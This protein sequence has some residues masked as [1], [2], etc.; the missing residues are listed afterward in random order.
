MKYLA[1]HLPYNKYL[2]NPATNSVTIITVSVFISVIANSVVN[3]SENFIK[4]ESMISQL[5]IG[6]DI[7][8]SLILCV[9]FPLPET[10]SL[11]PP[12]LLCL[13]NSNLSPTLS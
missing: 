5:Y 10:L 13:A 1:Q 9:L 2:V 6:S 3:E 12:C 7:L 8:R 4:T 11:P